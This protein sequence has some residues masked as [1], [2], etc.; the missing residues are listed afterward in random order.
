MTIPMVVLLISV[1]VWFICDRTSR[2]NDPWIVRVCEILFAASALV[3][4]LG[5]TG[6]PA[7]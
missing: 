4:L 2:L 6:K 7:F 5:V 3:V 1:V